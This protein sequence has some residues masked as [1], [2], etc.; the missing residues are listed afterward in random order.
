MTLFCARTTGMF[1]SLRKLKAASWQ[2]AFISAFLHAETVL[3]ASTDITIDAW[4]DASCDRR[5]RPPRR[6]LGAPFQK[7]LNGPLDVSLPNPIWAV[8]FSTSPAV[9]HTKIGCPG[10]CNWKLSKIKS[11][12]LRNYSMGPWSCDG[13]LMRQW[14]A[15]SHVAP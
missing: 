5:G 1:V 12:C 9:V 15:Q 3:F 2:P 8:G 10:L 6:P 11:P 14:Q 4:V 7:F 13:T